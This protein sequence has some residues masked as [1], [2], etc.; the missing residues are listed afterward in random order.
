VVFLLGMICGGALFFLGGHFKMRGMLRHGPM[1]GERHHMMRFVDAL[2]LD[3]VQQKQVQEILTRS[4]DDMM[5][6]FMETRDEIRAI[7]RED[8]IEK[9]DRMHPPHLE[10]H[11]H[12]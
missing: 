3:T 2:D 8:Q 12:H 7:L 6:H 5:R 11:E 10:M 9:F 1:P 4:R